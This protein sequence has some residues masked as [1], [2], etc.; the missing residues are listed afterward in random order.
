MGLLR[1]DAA[2]FVRG[3]KEKMLAG[4][5]IDEAAIQALI[6]ERYASRAAKNWARSDEIREGLLAQGIELKDGPDGTTWSV[7]RN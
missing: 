3:Q 7:K 2:V 1:E 6:K 4:L 5:S